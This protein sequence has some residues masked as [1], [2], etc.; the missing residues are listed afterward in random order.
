MFFWK[1][2][3]IKYIKLKMILFSRVLLLPLI[4]FRKGTSLVAQWLGIH[5]PMQGTRV[6]SLVQEDPTCHGATK[7][8]ATTTEPARHNY[9]S[10]HAVEPMCHNYW[11]H[12]P[13]IMKPAR[14]RAHMP[15][16]LSSCAATTEACVHLDPVLC[17]KRSHHNEKPA[18]R[19]EE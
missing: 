13:Q 3:K 11:A 18:H 4:V 9:W 1:N 16:L 12:A 7:P 10:P 19:N 6:Q 5:L 14:S 2:I 17:N 8:V 15:Q